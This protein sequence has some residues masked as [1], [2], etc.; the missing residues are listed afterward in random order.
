MLPH[1][2]HATA[3]AFVLN[4]M[5]KMLF[6]NFCPFRDPGWR[7]LCAIQKI[8]PD[9]LLCQCTA[10]DADLVDGTIKMRAITQ[11]YLPGSN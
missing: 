5:Q 7:Q 9:L 8:L 10:V 3:F 1:L 2:E 4:G 11:R 6:A